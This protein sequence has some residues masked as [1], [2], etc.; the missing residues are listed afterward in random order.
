MMKTFDFTIIA[1]GLN[2]Q[3]DA[4]L[5]RFFEAGCDDATISYQKGLLIL[6]FSRKAKNFAHAI[7]SAF[8]DVCKAGAKVERFEPDDLVSL[9]DIANRSGLT[10]AA[11]SNYSLGKRAAGKR[12]AQFPR[13]IARVTSESP[14]WDWVQ[15]SRWLHEHI[16]LDREIVLQARLVREANLITQI[17]SF[18]H[19]QFA[20]RL[21]EQINTAEAIEAA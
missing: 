4:F 10:R 7:S 17:K 12:A 8:S 11:I 5:D 16:K 1:S 15:V 2:P 14:L 20:K 18:P 3:E 21:E 19:D 9:S 13:P 6:E